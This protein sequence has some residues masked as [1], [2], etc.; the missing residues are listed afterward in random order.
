VK[1]KRTESSDL[2]TAEVDFWPIRDVV[3]IAGAISVERFGTSGL[4]RSLCP[5][6]AM[7]MQKTL[8]G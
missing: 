6:T 1:I 3:G 4:L 8:D 2:V 7:C 5:A